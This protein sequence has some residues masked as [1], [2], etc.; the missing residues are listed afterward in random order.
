MGNDKLWSLCTINIPPVISIWLMTT[1]QRNLHVVFVKKFMDP[2]THAYHWGMICTLNTFRRACMKRKNKT[3]VLLSLVWIWVCSHC[4]PPL[5][6]SWIKF[7][8]NVMVGH[9]RGFFQVPKRPFP[10]DPSVILQ[11]IPNDLTCFLNGPLQVI[12]NQIIPLPPDDPR[13]T[14]LKKSTSYWLWLP[15]CKI[16]VNSFLSEGELIWNS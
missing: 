13:K 10:F 7:V 5:P 3:W 11:G 1:S 6:Q 2:Q 16:W 14:L 12:K 4:P 8:K 15:W 9:V